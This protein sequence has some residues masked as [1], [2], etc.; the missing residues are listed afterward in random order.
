MTKI[1]NELYS[2]V[3][4]L[5]IETNHIIN[6]SFSGDYLSAFK[7]RGI[8]F[9][10]VRPYVPGDEVRLID[11][12]V[13]AKMQQPYV[14]IFRE[15][16][17]LSIYLLVDL[18]ASMLF[19]STRDNKKQLAQRISALLALVSMK[20]NDRIG[21][22]LFTDRVE[23]IIPPRK[24]RKHVLRLIEELLST[25]SRSA[26]TS[27]KNALETLNKLRIKKSIVFLISDFQDQSYQQTL[28]IT[29]RKHDLVPVIIRDPLE[30]S[31]PQ[32]GWLRL[33]NLETSEVILLSLTSQKL[34]N[35]QQNRLEQQQALKKYFLSLNIEI[36][37]LLTGQDYLNSL[38]KFF[39]RRSCRR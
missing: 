32:E 30:T 24:G 20:N 12:N 11:W 38:I 4:R 1:N 34:K 19:G 22:M 31:L 10:E 17:E 35:F 36:I 23:K 28:R 25:P 6:S 14:K 39:Q 9:D 33:K 3:K 2:Q 8:E 7:G 13:T 15:E 21:L 5:E 26:P 27:I 18:S 16:R 29:A 37:E